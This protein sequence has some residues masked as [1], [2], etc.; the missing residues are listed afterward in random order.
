[1]AQRQNTT[2]F[3]D[4]FSTRVSFYKLLRPSG[5]AW[6][7]WGTPKRV[8][9]HHNLSQNLQNCPKPVLLLKSEKTQ[10]SS[11]V[12]RNG[13]FK[14]YSRLF[15]YLKPFQN[16]SADV[17]DAPFT[18]LKREFTVLQVSLRGCKLSM[19]AT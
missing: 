16:A 15:F 3:I 14:K 18:T 11:K 7:G 8:Q 12:I 1:M 4:L 13:H 2:Y 19:M 9:T 5:I 10:F 6:N 17:P